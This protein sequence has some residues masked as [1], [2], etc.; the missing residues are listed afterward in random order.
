M[1]YR[2]PPAVTIDRRRPHAE[3]LP[4]VRADDPALERVRR[5][6]YWL[7]DRFRIPGTE[8]RVGL[9]SLIGLVP[10]VGD[11][12]TLLLSGYIVAEAWRLGVPRHLLARMA[13]NV[14]IDWVLG[15]IPLVGDL[16]D[17]GWKA[18]TR[19]LALLRRHLGEP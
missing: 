11:T 17:I 12:A 13:V 7:D 2:N 8:I 5:L 10:G 18:N 9:D 16:F 19:N 14:G 1:A 15:S 3:V 6:A 4:P